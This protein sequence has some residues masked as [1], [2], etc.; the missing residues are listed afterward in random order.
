MA[1]GPPVKVDKIE[2]AS[3]F[4]SAKSDSDAAG[5]KSSGVFGSEGLDGSSIA[6]A[7]GECGDSSGGAVC[8]R[9]ALGDVCIPP[10]FFK[11]GLGALNECIRNAGFLECL[12]VGLSVVNSVAVFVVAGA[13]LAGDQNAPG[14]VVDI[15]TVVANWRCK[16][17]LEDRR[18]GGSGSSGLNGMSVIGNGRNRTRSRLGF[19]AL[20]VEDI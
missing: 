18:I 17:A 13:V 15:E 5:L 20:N 19:N 4:D 12:D 10:R 2:Q 3:T 16:E 11:D 8:L 7:S 14:I 6:G 9:A 1:V